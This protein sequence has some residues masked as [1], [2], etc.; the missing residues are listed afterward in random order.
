M[1]LVVYEA[2]ELEVKL[3]RPEIDESGKLILKSNEDEDEDAITEV[4]EDPLRNEENVGPPRLIVELDNAAVITP[5]PPPSRTIIADQKPS[6]FLTPP[7]LNITL[8]IIQGII[9]VEVELVDKEDKKL[10]DK[11]GRV[12][13]R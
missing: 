1:L 9:C 4:N 2:R 6:S 7:Y 10:V 3:P 5:P 13:K 12:L 11:L 8:T